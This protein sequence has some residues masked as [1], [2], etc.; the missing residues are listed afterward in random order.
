MVLEVVDGLFRRLEK[1]GGL[2]LERERDGT[3][4]ALF[5]LD[6]V[7]DGADHAANGRLTYSGP[8]TFGLK[9][10]GGLWIDGFTPG[11]ATSARM[12]ATCIV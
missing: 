9:P 6:H 8:V 7:R 12:S 5:E 10:S 3:T 11:A 1:A 4:R 2:G